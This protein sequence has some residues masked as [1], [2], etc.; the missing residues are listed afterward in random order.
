MDLHG[1]KQAQKLVDYLFVCHWKKC[2]KELYIR[3]FAYK[4]DRCKFW[5]KFWLV[6]SSCTTCNLTLKKAYIKTPQPLI[7]TSYGAAQ[8]LNYLLHGWS[9]RKHL[10]AHCRAMVS[11]FHLLFSK[12][13]FLELFVSTKEKKNK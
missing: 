8:L 13:N 1:S 9:E 10:K 5:T 11:V 3:A 7:F 4:A 12:G 2:T 6:S